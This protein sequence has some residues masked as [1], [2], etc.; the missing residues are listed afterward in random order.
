MLSLSRKCLRLGP[1]LSFVGFV[2]PTSDDGGD[3]L[4]VEV[5][6]ALRSIVHSEEEVGF[7]FPSRIPDYLSE[8]LVS[9]RPSSQVLWFVGTY[10]GHPGV[11][12]RTLRSMGCSLSLVYIWTRMLS[13]PLAFPFLF[14]HM[15][16]RLFARKRA[17]P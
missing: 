14:V 17:K 4:W 15:F 6:S 13:L 9:A 10:F 11:F 1:L 16:T 2:R 8:G 7:L 12:S 3:F 5:D